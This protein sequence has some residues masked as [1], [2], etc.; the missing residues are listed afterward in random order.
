MSDLWTRLRAFCLRHR[1][2]LLG[3]LAAGG[4]IG[5]TIAIVD[6]DN[7]G[8]PDGISVVITVPVN[9]PGNGPAPAASP[10][11][12]TVPQEAVEQVKPALE[13]DLADERPAEAVQAAPGQLDANEA[14][15]DEV[16][17]E[18]EP[19]PEAGASAGFRGCVTRFVRNQSSRG[20]VRPIWQVLHYT[21]SPNR[22]GWDDVNAII[23]L[24]D[25]PSFAASSSFV[26]DG[27]GHCAYLVPIEAKPWTQAAG[28]PLSIS[29]EVINSGSEAAFM[30]SAGYE[31]L[32]DVMWQVSE[33]TG[34]PMRRGSVYPARP[35]IVQHKDGGLAWGG[36]VDITPFS[37]DQVIRIVAAKPAGSKPDRASDPL[38]LAHYPRARHLTRGERAT[39]SCLMKARRAARKAGSWGKT[40]AGTL[41]RA[42]ECKRVLQDRRD[43]L[44]QLPRR[45]GAHRKAR[46]AVLARI[47]RAHA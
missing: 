40:P 32:R 16:R 36:H 37:L 14:A 13:R 12:V 31:R 27:E 15:V 46:A 29:Y 17:S 30:Q 44:R 10:E 23:A 11:H 2:E 20:G 9:Q 5:F 26:I 22:P 25:R 42:R 45:R 7:D 28:N 4:A 35:G 3:L 8:R 24:F 43:E 1:K 47:I 21:V 19:L 34:I 33:R 38:Y 6:Q 39:A 41:D 18:L